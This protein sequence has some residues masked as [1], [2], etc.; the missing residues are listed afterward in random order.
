MRDTQSFGQISTIW[1]SLIGFSSFTSHAE[2]HTSC[3]NKLPFRNARWQCKYNTNWHFLKDLI[4]KTN[5]KNNPRGICWNCLVHGVYMS[6]YL[7]V[8]FFHYKTIVNLLKECW[9]GK[10]ERKKEKKQ[11]R[12]HKKLNEDVQELVS[13]IVAKK[14]ITF[15]FSCV[16]RTYTRTCKWMVK[17]KEFIILNRNL[18]MH[19]IACNQFNPAQNS[20]Q[21][22]TYRVQTVTSWP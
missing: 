11:K 3:S 16:I 7:G 4:N 19:W 2:N 13:P 12:N 10:K 8:F 6:R 17:E 18:L 9:W 21:L 15:D 1:I 20:E 5:H 14:L 22:T